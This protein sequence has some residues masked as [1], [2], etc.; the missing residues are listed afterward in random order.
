MS[1]QQSYASSQHIDF[2]MLADLVAVY[3]SL[4]KVKCKQFCVL[5]PVGVTRAVFNNND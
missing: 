1:I 5:F 2:K 4:L 3:I